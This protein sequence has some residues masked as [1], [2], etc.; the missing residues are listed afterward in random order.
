M[1][2]I[3]KKSQRCFEGFG[4]LEFVETQSE[5]R[6]DWQVIEKRSEDDPMHGAW[7][8]ATETYQIDR[9]GSEHRATPQMAHRSSFST[10]C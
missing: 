1:A 2:A 8:A 10:A 7:S 4:D 6:L 5:R 9:R 3:E